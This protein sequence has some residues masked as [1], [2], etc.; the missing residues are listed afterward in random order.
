MIWALRSALRAGDLCP[1]LITPSG[2][3]EPELEIALR[4]GSQRLP[5]PI[6]YRTTGPGRCYDYMRT[7]GLLYL[8]SKKMREAIEQEGFTGVHFQNATICHDHDIIE[9]YSVLH[10]SGKT[11]RHLKVVREGLRP[12][13]AIG[14]DLDMSLHDGSDFFRA[15]DDEARIYVTDRVRRII[16]PSDFSNVRYERIDT[17]LHPVN[18]RIER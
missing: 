9:G 15:M 4:N 11:G 5:C 1:S 6:H 14:M 3:W 18:F 16:R 8:V 10:V 17:A 13:S 2:D 12:R 7:T